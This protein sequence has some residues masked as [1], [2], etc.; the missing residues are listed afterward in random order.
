MNVKGIGG[1]LNQLMYATINCTN[2]TKSLHKHNLLISRKNHSILPHR[3]GLLVQ[4]I[5][6]GMEIQLDYCTGFLIKYPTNSF[7]E[8][9]RI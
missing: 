9:S 2:H 8:E 5:I 4:K 6:P 1:F 3:P 7:G